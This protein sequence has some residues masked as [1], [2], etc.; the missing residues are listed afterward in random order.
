[1][2]TVKNTTIRY[3]SDDGLSILK[4]GNDSVIEGNTIEKSGDYGIILQD[5]S[6]NAIYLNNFVGK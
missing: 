6:H 2:N 4:F 1:V 5:S 3:S